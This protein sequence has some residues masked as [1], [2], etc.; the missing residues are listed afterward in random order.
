M[1]SKNELRNIAAMLSDDVVSVEC[2]FHGNDKAYTYKAEK[3]MR[4][5]E[6]D[7]VAVSHT[8]GGFKVIR[9]KAV[10]K[11]CL[12]PDPE[13]YDYQWIIAKLD[14]T[15]FDELRRWEDEVADELYIAQ[16]SNAKRQMLEALGVP[17]LSTGAVRLSPCPSAK[18]AQVI[19]N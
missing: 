8:S 13:E 11:E 14:E 18:D 10:H 12:L 4:L 17:G 6:G 19:E 1:K 2:V 15:R 3:S 9:V 7:L 16:R 5:A